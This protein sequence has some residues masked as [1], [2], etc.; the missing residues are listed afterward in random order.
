[1]QPPGMMNPGKKLIL[2]KRVQMI[3]DIFF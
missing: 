1:M 2:F 3:S